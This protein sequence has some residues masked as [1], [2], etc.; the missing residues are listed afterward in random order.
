ML[1][2]IIELQDKAVASVIE[3]LGKKREITFRAPTGSGKTYMMADLMN[4]ILSG[5]DGVIFL[6]SSLSKGGLAK[7]NYDKFLEYSMNGAFKEIKPYLINT[8]ISGEESLF[9]PDGYNVYVL[10][11][12]LY[13]EDSLLMRGPMTNFLQKVTTNLFG[14]GLNKE[15]Y[16]I[17]DECHQA[18]KNLDS[19]AK[20]YF[21]K[22]INFSATPDAKKGQHPDVQITDDEAVSAKLIKH[23]EWGAEDDT[24]EDA[25][26]QFERIK[27]D[28]RNLLGVNPC[29]II[30]IS[31]KDKADEELNNNILPVLDKAEH[32][33]LKWM[34]IV[35]SEKKKDQPDV[36]QRRTNDIVGKRLPIHRWKD[37]AKSNTSTIDIIIFKMVISEG[38]DIPRA[39]M[40]Y[41]VRDSKSKQLD[42]QVMGR[43]RRNPRLLDFENLSDDAKELALTAWIWGIKPEQGRNSY[44]V[45]L[46][47][48]KF[49]RA[50]VLVKT[51]RL[52]ALSNKKGID[53]EAIISKEK[54]II[55]HKGIFDLYR[56]LRGQ[57]DMTKLCYEYS[58]SINNWLS[59]MEHF[60]VLKKEYEQFIC[61][62]SE[63]MELVSDEDGKEVLSSFPLV[64]LYTDN[65]NYLSIGEWVWVRKDSGE[66]F[67]FDSDAERKWASI[68]KDLSR[69]GAKQIS[70]D[71]HSPEFLDEDGDPIK[72][73]MWGKNYP[74]GSDIKFQYYLNGTHD[75]FPDFVLK[76]NQDRIHLFEVK[77]L[78]VKAGSNINDGEYQKKLLALSE[79]YKYCSLLTGQYFYL[80]VL[81]DN[82]WEIYRFVNGVE[83]IISEKAFRK[84]VL[85]LLA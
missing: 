17:K 12:D 74:A 76:D 48:Q 35:D 45:S 61:D 52:K 79:C 67:S 82:K 26:N 75:S 34:I 65:E 23:I 36:Y 37:Y 46:A 5:N 32:Q 19:L 33:D 1:Q 68:L 30:Q 73:Y 51:T 38:W 7:Q 40:L 28:Y 25:I 49:T 9:I 13:K 42:E 50:Q 78:N 44:E 60:D 54:P 10:P 11:R 41:Q 63:S 66:D 71:G 64:S 57:E 15:I 59:F 29:L 55:H 8:D 72:R 21:S 4:Q 43:V 80:P 20:E 2:E 22:I 56:K 85:S 14:E 27:G 24:V 3:L 6:V 47:G 69:E 84:S 53:V 18:T 62:Y 39:C 81:K 77:S 16:V 31:N 58:S 70:D 83:D